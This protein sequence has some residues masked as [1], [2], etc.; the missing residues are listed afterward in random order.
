VPLTGTGTW[1]FQL[2]PI[3]SSQAASITRKR[4]KKLSI[5]HQRVE[6]QNALLSATD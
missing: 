6:L 5:V 3:K 1:S 2:L 4:G